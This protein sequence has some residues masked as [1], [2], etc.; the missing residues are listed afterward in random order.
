MKY[1]LYGRGGVDGAPG[2]NVK[3][4]RVRAEFLGHFLK[5]TT[6]GTW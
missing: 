2:G 5:A 3:N 1:A 4:K 6:V